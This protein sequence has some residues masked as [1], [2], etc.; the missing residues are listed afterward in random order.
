MVITS[1][2]MQSFARKVVRH[3]DWRLRQISRLPLV[4]F[5]RFGSRSWND[6]FLARLSRRH[7]G[8]QALGD[9]VAIYVIYAPKG[10]SPSHIDA[11]KNMAQAGYAALVI[12]NSRLSK[13]DAERLS[14]HSWLLLERVNFGYDFGAYRDGL[15]LLK[16]WLPGLKRLVLA[17][18]SVWLPLPGRPNWF[19]QAETM[20]AGFVGATSNLGVA[21]QPEERWFDQAW[22][23]DPTLRNYHLC[24]F[25]LSFGPEVFKSSAF[26]RFWARLPLSNDKHWVVENGE[27]ALTR[28]LRA[29]GIGSATTTPLPDLA[30]YV[31]RLS[32]PRLIQ[33]LQRLI[34]PEDPDLRQLRDQVLAEAPVTRRQ[35]IEAFIFYAVALTGPA[36]CLADLAVKEMNQPF[37]K[38]TPLTRE[39]AGAAASLD[40]LRKIGAESILAEAQVLASGKTLA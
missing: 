23:Y 5:R 36:Y 40:I 20:A 21:P 31:A 2:R 34:I 17:N 13:A 35:R 27:V 18:D 16:P 6:L 37:M 25:L 8:S 4:A 28:V 38:K 12:A 7:K 22:D 15:R 30:A 19:Q 33:L 3:V 11:L 29:A 14:Q 32:E 26:A 10:I 1:L 24:S 9:R 39:A